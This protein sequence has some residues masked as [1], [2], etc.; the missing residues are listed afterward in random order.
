MPEIK[1]VSL[2]DSLVLH[3]R[4][5]LKT[6]RFMKNHDNEKAE[7]LLTVIFF[8]VLTKL[9][10]RLF[11]KLN[12]HSIKWSIVYAHYLVKIKGEKYKWLWYMYPCKAN[13][14]ND[15]TSLKTLSL[16]TIS[17]INSWQEILQLE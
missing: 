14:Y 13:S 5:F 17:Q 9:K 1:I 2:P 7:N 11:L 4:N 10:R 8:S 3:V 15:M 12:W 16:I 6:C